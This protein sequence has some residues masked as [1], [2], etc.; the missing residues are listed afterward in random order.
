[1]PVLQWDCHFRISD[2]SLMIPA[3]RSAHGPYIVPPPSGLGDA[4][5]L[6]LQHGASRSACPTAPITASINLPAAVLVSNGW[7]P[8]MDSHPQA[9]LLGFQ[10]GD[11]LQQ[12]AER[13]RQPVQLGT[14]KVSPSRT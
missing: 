9:D 1:M 4:F 7:P 5:P 6:P 12:V 2:F 11:D 14:V 8:D 10:A 3:E 13:P